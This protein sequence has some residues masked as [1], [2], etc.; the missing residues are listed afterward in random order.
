M[1]NNDQHRSEFQPEIRVG[2]I[3]ELKVHQVSDEELT[4]LEQGSSQSLFLN[5]GI[6]ALSVAASF[7]IALLTTQIASTRVFDVFVIITGLCFLAG[8]VL[9]ILWF[10]TRQP[11]SN[12]VR[13]IRNRMP[14]KGEA[15]VLGPPYSEY[16]KQVT[17][18]ASNATT[19]SKKRAE[20]DLNHA[21]GIEKA[22]LSSC[23]KLYYRD[24][25]SKKMRFLGGG[26]IADG[27][28]NNE[29]TWRIVDNKLE[30]LNNA[31][32]VFSRFRHEPV[33]KSFHI[34]LSPDILCKFRQRMEPV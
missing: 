22:L 20:T 6:G 9:L 13:E 17:S 11:I 7:L 32:A 10:C 34:E 28:N 14:P 33:T 5:F 25:N 21:D 16:R 24:A 3:G 12:L 27:K 4:R 30:L 31:G 2:R 1:N 26:E 23:Y 15:Q 29:H 8:I 18:P 19:S